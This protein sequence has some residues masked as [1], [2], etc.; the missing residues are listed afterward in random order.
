MLLGEHDTRLLPEGGKARR[1]Y[2]LLRGEIVS[3]RIIPGASL[4]GEQRLAESHGVS[5]VTVRRALDSLA[6]DG[7]I[8]KRVG[9]GSIVT[10][11]GDEAPISADMATLIP[12]IVQMGQE[13]TARLLSFSYG[14]APD[15][16]ATALGLAGPK[17]VQT[18]VRVRLVEDTPFS[19]LTTHVPDDIARSYS[20]ADLA[21]TPLFSLLERSGVSVHSASQSVTAT[22]AAPDVA[23]ALGVSV[24][25][26]LLALR[27]VVR[28]ASGRGVE[29]L[30][31]ALS[32]RSLP[33]G[34]EPVARGRGRCAPLGTGDRRAAG[35]RCAMS[36]PRTLF[37]KLW[38]AH[39]VIRAR[40]WRVAPLGRPAP[41]A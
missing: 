9:A 18:A 5:R 4:P 11:T 39:E 21:T 20:E 2:L 27:R 17:Q 25:S 31:G 38:D 29:Y 3:G 13:T 15:G 7:L 19:H 1:V 23:D 16:V 41:G 32:S 10:G 8:E 37:D 24:G 6:A 14:P 30:S 12:Q 26:A 28:D 35:G 34:D 33:A 22:L 40:G 36:V